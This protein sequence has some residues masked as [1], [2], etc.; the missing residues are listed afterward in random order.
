MT[1]LTR[2]NLILLGG[3]TVAAGAAVAAAN[4][5]LVDRL[6]GFE[7]LPPT[8][9][10]AVDGVAIRGTDPVAYFREGRPVHGDAAFEAEW[11]GARWRFANGGNR[12]EFLAAPDRFAPRYGGFCAWAVAAR[13]ELYSIQPRNWSIVDDRLYLNFNDDIQ[14]RWEADIPGFI[15]EADRRWPEIIAGAA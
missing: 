8:P 12:D 5:G 7:E 4:S 10:F 6:A 15:A 9:V 13:G 1:L 2:R 11:N 14:R 3:A